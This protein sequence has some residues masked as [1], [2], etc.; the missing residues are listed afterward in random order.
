MGISCK[1]LIAQVVGM[2]KS[3]RGPGRQPT[4]YKAEPTT[5][6]LEVKEEEAELREPRAH[7][8]GRS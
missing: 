3:H 2:Q 4:I 6:Q 1:K 5:L 7:P 8:P